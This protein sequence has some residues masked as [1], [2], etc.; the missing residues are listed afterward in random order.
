MYIFVSKRPYP[1]VLTALLRRPYSHGTNWSFLQEVCF[2]SVV[3]PGRRTFGFAIVPLVLLTAL[4]TA[5][6]KKNANPNGP[7]DNSMS[8]PVSPPNPNG[9]IARF[10]SNRTANPA[11]KQLGRAVAF[12]A[13]P[14]GGIVTYGFFAVVMAG[15]VFGFIAVLERDDTKEP[16]PK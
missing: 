4:C 2:L 6:G 9:I 14:I 8:R 12:L 5:C 13:G 15:G 7:G 1:T 3:R 10:N 16:G 11:R